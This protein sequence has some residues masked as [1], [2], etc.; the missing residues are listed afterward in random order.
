MAL[1]RIS[2]RLEPLPP[3]PQPELVLG[4]ALVLRSD[5][6]TEDFSIGYNQ[7]TSQIVA[8][9]ASILITCVSFFSFVRC[10]LCSH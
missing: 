5:T 1:D 6:G 10:D 3:V 4:A 2:S 9:Y 8:S 7:P